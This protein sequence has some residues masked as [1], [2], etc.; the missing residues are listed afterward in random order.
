MT[1][2]RIRSSAKISV[3][4]F[5]G[6]ATLA[7]ASESILFT[8]K[9]LNSEI[10]SYRKIL[11]YSFSDATWATCVQSLFASKYSVTLLLVF[12]LEESMKQGM[13]DMHDMRVHIAQ[14]SNYGSSATGSFT[15]CLSED[16]NS[17]PRR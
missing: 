14:G 5:S 8:E 13:P 4:A 9:F 7:L 6:Q 17:N 11:S 10:F 2:E 3:T 15:F 12:L 16:K 1:N